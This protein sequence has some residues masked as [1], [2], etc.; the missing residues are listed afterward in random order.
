[1]LNL[2]ILQLAQGGGPGGQLMIGL[3]LMLVVFL[4]HHAFGQP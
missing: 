2:E 4:C 3:I 1:M